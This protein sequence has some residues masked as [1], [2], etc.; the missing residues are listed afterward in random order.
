MKKITGK[1][2]QGGKLH[3]DIDKDLHKKF[4][5]SCYENDVSMTDVLLEVIKNYIKRGNNKNGK[6]NK[7]KKSNS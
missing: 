7:D 4:K 5:I 2:T 6:G 1:K 3:I